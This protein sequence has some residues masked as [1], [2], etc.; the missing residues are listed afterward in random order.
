MQIC[1]GI[2]NSLGVLFVWKISHLHQK[3]HRDATMHT[4]LFIH[5]FI[6][7]LQGFMAEKLNYAVYYYN[8]NSTNI[9]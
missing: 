2:L 8:Y 6:C 1:G 3:E 5:L 7:L 9:L 4:D